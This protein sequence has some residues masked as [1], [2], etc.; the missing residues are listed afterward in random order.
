MADPLTFP[1]P[2]PSDN[3]VAHAYFSEA[4]RHLEDASALHRGNRYPGAITSIMKAV[5]LSLK[6]LL[7]LNGIRGWHDLMTHK[8]MTHII[9]MKNSTIFENLL[10]AL[11]SQ[12]PTVEADIQEIERLVP[13]K[14]KL[15]KLTLADAENTEYPY[16][17]Y[18]AGGAEM[19]RPAKAFDEARSIKYFHTAYRLLDAMQKLSPEIAAWGVELCSPL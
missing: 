10:N 13:D 5:E 4:A 2:F 11:K 17:V 19:Y 7:I 8:V 3:E 9:M 1:I 18:E 15:D 12:M 16:F 14:Q 6:S